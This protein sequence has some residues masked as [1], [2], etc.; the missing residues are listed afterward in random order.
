VP[1]QEVFVWVQYCLSP[2]KAN[3]LLAKKA[4]V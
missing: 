3:L 2:Y 1:L 4:F